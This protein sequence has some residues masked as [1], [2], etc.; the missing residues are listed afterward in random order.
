MTVA[1]SSVHVTIPVE[2]LL[3]DLVLGSVTLDKGLAQLLPM[4]RRQRSLNRFFGDGN[5]NITARTATFAGGTPENLATKDEKQLILSELQ[6]LDSIDPV[7]F[8]DDFEFLWTTGPSATAQINPELQRAFV[9]A[10]SKNFNHTIE[11]IM[12]RGDIGGGG[13]GG[14]E[15][16]DGW[17]KTI[18]A[19][20]NVN[21]ATPLGP[22]TAANV[23]SVLEA[24]VAATPAEVQELSN[25]TI[26]MSDTD[27]YLYRE[28][29]RALDFKGNNIDG[30]I[31]DFFGGFPIMS[32][33]GIPA[34]RMFLMN[35]G[36]GDD[37]QLKVGVWAD[38]DRF[39]IA[40]GKGHDLD[41]II[42]ARIRVDL[43]VNFVYGKEI[44]EY[45]TV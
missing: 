44:T 23:I 12:W 19:D 41:D 30:K 9:N 42:G 43:G 29:A 4:T 1:R 28:A 14:I 16:V 15:L 26:L 21:N 22:V 35:T 45:T 7:E 24:V 17:I 2:T 20:A 18:D 37:S 13:S 36:G 34:G 40:M 39:N 11:R 33:H 25:P 32:T 27:K 6:L 10:L 31:P 38:A 3:E 5:D 8:N